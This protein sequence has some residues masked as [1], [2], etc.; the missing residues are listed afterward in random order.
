MP[1]HPVFR[2]NFVVYF[3]K[4]QLS[5]PIPEKTN[6][7]ILNQNNT[8][9]LAR[10]YFLTAVKTLLKSCLYSGHYKLW[11]KVDLFWFVYCTTTSLSLLFICL[12]I[13]NNISCR[14]T[15]F[16]N[17]LPLHSPSAVCPPKWDLDYCLVPD[18][19]RVG[20]V[21]WLLPLQSI[22]FL[23]PVLYWGVQCCSNG[24][25]IFWRYSAHKV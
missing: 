14:D 18:A 12:L 2:V 25:H 23:F 6:L 11:T 8:N 7:L 3:F 19:G 16:M 15:G 21:F 24:F 17:R 22:A 10:Q 20:R 13:I 1:N 9:W 4:K 5:L